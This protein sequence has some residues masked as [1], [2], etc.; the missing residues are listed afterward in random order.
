MKMKRSCQFWQ[1]L[2]CLY[3][4]LIIDNNTITMTL[5]ELINYMEKSE[6]DFIIDVEISEEKETENE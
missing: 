3:E 4:E 5:N 2:F 6:N 1:L